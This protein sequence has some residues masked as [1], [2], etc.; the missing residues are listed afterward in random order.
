M[1]PYEHPDWE[2]FLRAVVASPDD[3]L[4]RLVAADWLDEQGESLRAEFIR[5][6]MEL[7]R[8]VLSEERADGLR[9]RER[10][11]LQ[12][13][14]GGPLWAL[15]SCPN[16]VRMNFHYPMNSLGGL[17][18]AEMHRV[19]F[20]RGFPHALICPANDWMHYGVGI[21]PRQ[22]LEKLTLTQ[23][24]DLPLHRWWPMLPTLR[25]LRG[26][27]VDSR[28]ARLPRMLREQLPSVEVLPVR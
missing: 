17:E 3:D 6:Q 13:P 27:T 5:I 7:V 20:R 16:V 2:A 11:L 15:E 1:S 26:L 18:L 23:C 4:P 22:P 21:V 25:Y 14:T 8:S 19:Q 9:Q 24:D 10:E 28:W 12:H